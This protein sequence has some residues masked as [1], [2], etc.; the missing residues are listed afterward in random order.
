M[1]LGHLGRR[2]APVPVCCVAGQLL[3]QNPGIGQGLDGILCAQKGILV[4]GLPLQHHIL[5]HTVPVP[6]HPLPVLL[7]LLPHD[8]PLKDPGLLPSGPHIVG[9]LPPLEV[10]LHRLAVEKDHRNTGLLRFVHDH[11]RRGAVHHVDAQHIAAPVQKAVHLLHLEGLVALAVGDA[12]V[13]LQQALPLLLPGQTLHLLDHI[14]DK[15]VVLLIDGH[16]HP[17][18][19]R[20][21]RIP[22]LAAGEQKDAGQQRREHSGP[23]PVRT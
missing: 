5:E 8:L 6:V 9:F 16:A 12:Q 17:D 23:P 20:L 22:V 7:P 18:S 4:A 14:G 13:D 2:L 19:L 3:H 15:G 1:P 11:G 10:L 21:L